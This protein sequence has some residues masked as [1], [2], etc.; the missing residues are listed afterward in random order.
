[1]GQVRQRQ[2]AWGAVFSTGYAT[3]RLGSWPLGGWAEYCL[4]S[5]GHHRVMMAAGPGR[6]GNVLPVAGAG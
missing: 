4:L 3:A 2:P 5:R 6:S 1:M